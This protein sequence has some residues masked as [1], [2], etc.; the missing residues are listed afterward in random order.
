MLS[1]IQVLPHVHEKLKEG[2]NSIAEKMLFEL[3][4]ANPK[5]FDY[6][7]FDEDGKS[8]FLLSLYDVVPKMLA[9]YSEKRSQFAPYI[10][11][12]IRL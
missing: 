4:F 7:D 6:D 2:K 5:L 9:E 11:T 1:D 10:I 8:E 12:V 3:I